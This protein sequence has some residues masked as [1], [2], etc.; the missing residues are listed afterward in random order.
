[1]TQKK[2]TA[3]DIV[4]D[5][6]K[7]PSRVGLYDLFHTGIGTELQGIHAGDEEYIFLALTESTYRQWELTSSLVKNDGTQVGVRSKTIHMRHTT[8]VSLR[9][10]IDKALEFTHKRD[11]GY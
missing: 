9:M 1:M 8:L 10:A 11:G 7:E 5:W 4:K 3:E 6:K 2:K